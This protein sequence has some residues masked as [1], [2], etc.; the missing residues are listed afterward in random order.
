MDNQLE[1]NSLDQTIK[2]NQVTSGVINKDLPF[3]PVEEM[4]NTPEYD[5]YIDSADL[6][7]LQEMA[8]VEPL[9]NKYASGAYGN[10]AVDRPTLATDTYDPVVQ[11]NPLNKEDPDYFNRLMEIPASA[12]LGP[13]EPGKQIVSPKYAGI[14]QSNFQR[15]YNHP[16]FNKLGFTPYSDMETTYN[17][18]STVYDDYTRMWGQFTSLAGTGF[19]SG[20]RA[21]GDLFGGDYIGPDLESADEF[22]DAMAIGNSSRE[23]G[24]A[25]TNNML[26]NS[27]YTMGII[28][29]IALE[30][31]ALAAAAGLQGG[32]NPVSD[33]M[34]MSAT[35]R[36]IA[37]LKKIG[38]SVANSFSVTRYAN[39]TREVIKAFN[40]AEN[41]KDFW[42]M[43]KGITA[44]SGL[45]FFAPETVAAIRNLKTTANGTQ[46]M[47]NLAKQSTVFGGFY[48]DA[49][50]LNLAIAESKLEGGM[51]YNDMVR[52]GSNILSREN[53]GQPVTPEQMVNIEDKASRASFKTTLINAP[54][55]FA[56]NQLV[57]GNAFGGF[58]RSFGRLVND[59]VSDVGRRI[60][61]T[62]AVKSPFID[63]GESTLFNFGK[64]FRK[65][66]IN[67]GVKGNLIKSAGV[68]LRY[69]AANFG[70][71]IQEISQEAVSAGTKGYYTALLTDPLAGGIDLFKENINSAVSSQFTAQ[72]FD[73][74]MSG[75]LMGGVVSGPQKIFFQGIPAIYSRVSDPKAYAEHKENRKT[76]V[77]SIVKSYNEINDL[78]ADDVNSVFDPKKFEFLIQHQI[79]DAKTE[80]GFMASQFD[81]INESDYAKFQNIYN[82]M[83][84]GGAHYFEQ[85][86][87]DFMKLSDVEL[88]E[89]FPSS[90]KDV[91]S[92]KIRTRLQDMVNQIGKMEDNYTQLKDTF[93]NPFNESAFDISTQSTEREQELIRKLGWDHVRHLAMFTRDG[94]ERAVERSNSIFQTLSADPLF[95]NM[96]A[97][98]IT[99]LLDKDTIDQEINFLN[100]EIKN[101]K[102]DKSQA[103]AVKEKK[104]KVKKL[105][106]FKD[107]LNDLKNL[108]KDGSFDRRKKGKLKKAF[109]EYVR[110]L[111][112]ST[113]SFV[114]QD[115]MDEA[116]QQI[117]DYGALKGRA[118]V[119]DKTI[120]ALANPKKFNEVFERSEIA[121]KA[122][123]KNREEIFRKSVNKYLDT[124]EQNA[125]L[126]QINA[127]EGAFGTPIPEVQEVIQFGLTNNVETL[128]T[129]YNE[130]GLINTVNDPVAFNEINRL[131]NAYAKAAGPTQADVD[132][133]T[134]E[135]QTV[136]NREKIQEILKDIDVEVPV[137]ES[138]VLTS[139]L[140]KA[141][142]KYEGTQ[143]ALL[144]KSVKYKE[145]VNTQEGQTHREAFNAIKK[146][147][148]DNDKT[149]NDSTRQLT[150]EQ[151][152]NDVGLI[153]WLTSEE[154][155]NNDLV[156]QVLNKLKIPLTNI[157]GQDITLSGKGESFQGNDKLGIL[158]DARNANVAVLSKK[159]T[160]DQGNDSLVYQIIDSKTGELISGDMLKAAG[161]SSDINFFNKER[162]A[163]AAWKLV[164]L[165]IPNDGTFSFDGVE[166]L[167]FGAKV[168]SLSESDDKLNPIEYVIWSNP[169]KVIKKEVLT[170]IPASAVTLSAQEK[171]NNNVYINLRPGQFEN[172]YQ[173]EEKDFQL[174]PQNVS[175]INYAEPVTPYGG[176]NPEENDWSAAKQRYYS[177]LSV[178]SP[179]D[180]KTLE[181]VVTKDPEGGLT[182]SQYFIPGLEANPYILNKKAKYQIGVRTNSSDVQEK[183]DAFNFQNS[184]IRLDD[185]GID[186]NIFAYMPNDNFEFFGGVDPMS[187]T[188]QQLNQVIGNIE[189]LKGTLTKDQILDK[190][191]N[192]WAK[193]GLLISEVDRLMKDVPDGSF[194]TIAQSELP[195][196]LFFNA[197]LGNVVYDNS[198][199]RNLKELV[200]E[201]AADELG[202]YLIYQAE[203][204]KKG[205]R[206]V[207][208]SNL[209]EAEMQALEFR[210]KKS[211][212][213]EE[214]NKLLNG[215]D[216]YMAAVLLPDG[217][218]RLVPLKSEVLSS[219]SLNEIFVKLVERAQVTQKEN[220]DGKNP[221][222]NNNFNE[223]IREEL[224]IS[225]HQGLGIFLNVDIYGNIQL[226]AV[227]DE[228][229]TN[230]KL[231]KK[232]VNDKKL[233]V[234]KKLDDLIA[235]ANESDLFKNSV[236]GPQ[237]GSKKGLVL[238]SKN[239]RVSYGREVGI[240]ELIEKTETNA[241]P[242]VS[243]V[244]KIEIG[245]DSA[246]IQA[247]R[248]STEGISPA[249]S[250]TNTSTERLKTSEDFENSILILDEEEYNEYK[251]D[252]FENLPTEY[253]DDI[254]NKLLKEEELKEREKEVYD[255]RTKTIE[256][257]VF[258]KGGVTETETTIS[259]LEKLTQE[260][261]IL[262]DKLV[263]GKTGAAKLK[264][265]RSSDE[266]KALNKKIEDFG[267]IANKISP[268]LTSEDV[269]NIDVFM[270]WAKRNLPDYINIQDIVTLGNNMKAGGVR[271]GAFALNLN[272]LAGGLNISGTLYTGANS[273]F[274]YHEA[275][276]GVFRMLLTDTEISKYLSVARKEVRAKLRAEGK[277]F[278]QE[279]KMFRNS[280]DTYSN[281]SQSRLE[282]EYYE[283][284]LANEFE[285]FKT[286]PRS[287]NT[288]SSVKSLFTRMLEWI[289]SFFNSYNK[290]EL[291][292]L[293]EN[294]DAGKYK[295]SATVL[296]QF[297]NGLAAGVTLEANA[298]IP[299]QKVSDNDTEGYL[300][301]DSVVADSLVSSIA[302]MYLSRVSKITEP[303]TN[304]GEV[305]DKVLEDFYNLYDPESE[306]NVDKS[307]LQKETLNNIT[308][309]IEYYLDPLQ[310]QVYNILN[311]VDGQ[312]AEEE[313]NTEY[314]EDTIGV[315]AS[316]QWN[317]DAST[318]GGINSTPKQIR[319]Y[320]ATTT[321]SATDFFGNKELIKELKDDNGVVIRKAEPLIIPV[322]FTEI[323]NGMMKSAKNISDPKKML[324]TMYFF[325]QENAAT[326]AVVTRVLQD[327]GISEETLL[328]D[329]PLPNMKDPLL[330]QSIIK[331][332]ENF[333]VD[334]LFTQRDI[335]G[336]ILTY[337][338][339]Q[340]DDI[341]SQVDRWSQAWNDAYKKI[342]SNPTIAS[343]TEETLTSLIKL[344]NETKAKTS[345]KV[346][347]DARKYSQQLFDL[348]G[349][350]LSTQYLKYSILYNRVEAGNV[351]DIQQQA[352]VDLHKYEDMPLTSEVVR[353]MYSL[354]YDKDDI[355]SDGKDGMRSRIVK[356][357]KANAPFDETIGLSVFKNSE[358]NFV[359]SHQKPTFHLK[360]VEA[361]NNPS[362][363]EAKKEN[364]YLEDNYLL[365]SPAF[366]QMSNEKR[367][368][369]IRVAGT[370]V[371]KINST[372]EEINENISGV[373][374]KST[375][376][377]F[378]P[379][380]FALSL[381][382]SYTAL[383]NPQSGKVD[384]VEV[385]DPITNE[386]S[387][388]ALAPSLIRVL[389]SADTGDM[390]YMNVIKAVEFESGN[391]GAVKI[392]DKVIDV[393]VNSINTE[394]KRIQRESNQ[395][396][397]TKEE[398]VGYNI[399][400]VDDKGDPL[401]MR[402]Y[403]LHNSARLLTSQVKNQLEQIAKRSDKTTLEQA[404]LEQ[405][406]TMDDLRS[407]VRDKLDLQFE[408][409]KVELDSLDI[410]N[411]ISLNIKEGLIRAGV[412]STP[413]LEESNYLLNLN[414]DLNHNLK[415]IFLND[416][417]NTQAINE[418]FL[419][420]QA[421]TLKNGVDAIKRAK[422]QNAAY[423]SA[424]SAISAP[425][426][427]VNHSVD[428]ISLVAIEEPREAS[429]LTGNNIDRADAQMWMTTKA[430]RY[431]TFAF[432]QLTPLIANLYDKIEQGEDITSWQIFGENV[433]VV[434]HKEES[435]IV[436]DLKIFDRNNIEVFKTNSDDRR[437][438]F[439][440][441]KKGETVKL[442][443]YV[444]QDNAMLISKK[445]VYFDGTTFIKMSAFVLTP[446]LTSD[447]VV[448]EDGSIS[449]VA[450]PN[451]VELHNLRMKLE[452]IESLPG[453]NT[454]GIA[455]PLTALKMLK[456]RVQTLDRLNEDAP[457]KEG[458]YTTLSAMDMGLQSVNP[459]NKL[460]SVDPTQ[461]K[462]IVTSEQIDSTPI[463][464]MG[465][466]EKD[467]VMTVGDVRRL[468]NKAISSR[469][470][471]NFKNKRNLIFTFDG[472]M[473]ELAISKT[474]GKLTPNLMAFLKYATEGLKAS[475]SSSQLLEFFSTENGEQKYNLNSQIT[476]NRFEQLF[477][478]YLSKG[479]FAEKQPA[480][481]LTLVSD[482]GLPVYR[483][484]FSV[485]A[486]GI[487]ERS[488]VIREKVWEKMKNKP[489]IVEFDTL[490]RS[491][492][493][494]EG[495]VVLDRLRSNVREYDSKGEFT[496][497]RYTEMLMPAH[498]QSVMDLVENG[499]M[500]M[501][502]AI[503]KMFAIRIPSQDN[504]ST[505]NVK[506]VDFLPAF[507]GSSAAFA[508]E[509]IEI[510]G[511]DFDIDKVYAQIK[512]F[513]VRDGEFVEYGKAEDSQDKYDEY[514]QYVQEKVE[515]KG[516]AYNEALS[517]YKNDNQSVRED[518][519]AALAFADS[520]TDQE[521]KKW[522][523]TIIALD[524]LG[525]PIS[526]EQ[527]LKYLKDH[528]EPYQAP[529]NNEV[530]DY[531]YALMGNT[532]VTENV[533]YEDELPISY[534]PANLDILKAE[535][536]RLINLS[537][538][539]PNIFAIR[540]EEDSV[541]INNIL[542]KIKAFKNNKGAAIG[543]I[544]SPNVNLSLLTEYGILIEDKSKVITINGVSFDNFAVL[545]EQTADETTGVRKQ[546]IISSLI[547]MATDDAKERLVAKLGLNRS[548]LGL[549]GNLT[550]LGM[551][552]HTSLLLIN[553]P[554]IQNIYNKALNK[555][556]KTDPGVKTL[557]ESELESF[558]VR[559]LEKVDV[560]DKLLYEA[561]ARPADLSASEN[562][563]ILEE[564][565]KGVQIQEFTAKMTSISNLTTGL[566]K[567]IAAVNKK[568]DDINSLL[569]PDAMMDLSKIYKGKTWQS[570]YVEIFN[571]VVDQI[572]PVTF[573]SA[574]VSFQTILNKTLENVNQKNIE[575]N[576]DAL[577]AVSR[578][579]L[580]Y[581]T[582]KAY[583]HN[584]LKSENNSQV[585]AN[586]NNNFI[587]PVSENEANNS[588]VK[589]IDK[590]RA[591][592]DMQENFFLK[593]FVQLSTANDQSNQTGMN[594][595][596]ANT[597]LSMN[598][599]QKVDLQTSFAQIYGTAETKNDALSII[600]YM[601]VK[602]GLQLKYG[603]LL[604]A[605]SPFIMNGF[606]SQIDTAN[607]GLRNASDEK[608]KSTFGLTFDEFQ[609][610][611]VD[612]YMQSNVNNALLNTYTVL[613]QISSVSDVSK[614]LLT[615]RENKSAILQKG[616]GKGF[617]YLRVKY[618]DSFSNPIYITYV[619]TDSN[620]GE[621]KDSKKIISDNYI[622]VPTY[623]SN[624]QSGIG[625]M[626]GP[627]PTYTENRAYV[628][629]K[630]L[631]SNEADKTVTLAESP[632]SEKQEAAESALQN[633]NA[634]IEATDGLVKVD[635]KNIAD[636]TDNSASAEGLMG[637]LVVQS[638][639]QTSEFDIN[640]L[641]YAESQEESDS[642][643]AKG[644]AYAGKNDDG[645]PAYYKPTQPTSEVESKRQFQ[646][647]VYVKAYDN[648]RNK[649][650]SEL[651]SIVEAGKK[652]AR[653]GGQSSPISVAKSFIARKILDGKTKELD[654]QFAKPT[655]IGEVKVLSRN[656]SIAQVAA[657]NKSGGNINNL[658]M[659][660]KDLNDLNDN[661]V[662]RLMDYGFGKDNVLVEIPTS[663]VK[664]STDVVLG[665]E[666]DYLVEVFEKEGQ[667]NPIILDKNFNIIEGRH[668]LFAAKKLGL[669]IKAYMPAQ[670][671][672]EE[673][674]NREEFEKLSRSELSEAEESVTPLDAQLKLDLFNA[675]ANDYSALTN[676]WTKEIQGNA[677]FKAKLREQKIL[678]LEDFIAL[679]K[680]GIYK[681]DEDFLESLGCL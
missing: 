648:L 374:Y 139:I 100:V 154:G 278:E 134:E 394:Y 644:Y 175:R 228:V 95:E 235:R 106:A 391:S 478:S 598:P 641:E 192:N 72:G 323:Y 306:H 173:L 319:A 50:S 128:R 511:A 341:N 23:G 314:F 279:L 659:A 87:R 384:Y 625:F 425:E 654:V 459:S 35:A 634:N 302:A 411:S 633:Q 348:T 237:T 435:Y 666:E 5:A 362:V 3:I 541:D 82:V 525:L 568:K 380:E 201:G 318:I 119:Y 196:G 660:N 113:G 450:K 680:E 533:A 621:G 383:A 517:L 412:K 67:A 240:E 636:I 622:E 561:I 328:N 487:P 461:I 551:P 232:D 419:G 243:G 537:D 464:G 112:K 209:E 28:S 257:I 140:E 94:F 579:L 191:R 681:S 121:I 200:N 657:G 664:G 495:L 166:D 576:E 286:N 332:F 623:G 258:S 460:E 15:Y 404:M 255:A 296:N 378:T 198:S 207:P 543:A 210:V 570:K 476:V 284:Y 616:I 56:T 269:E 299:Y 483:R 584:Q 463:P 92:G 287:T 638:T 65:S 678:S 632:E 107:I 524:M 437:A 559:S 387:K 375:Y 345:A 310:K 365:N 629:S 612:G 590:L 639:Q 48:R 179:E 346:T 676:Y 304:R 149:V 368:R 651:K 27:G 582:I 165:N 8:N 29:S 194:L 531:K 260:R 432:G 427:G 208:I 75:F 236:S 109:Q 254:A 540:N 474:K 618:D 47:V 233:T 599:L 334:Y 455:A 197:I 661:L 424:Y 262:R 317:T 499:T 229:W 117:V 356:M 226:S 491:E 668:R 33:A 89:A 431:M 251:A 143:L 521:Y 223:E 510:S 227:K 421:V 473:D 395:D 371:G 54:L 31:V 382:N 624:Q 390:M 110:F 442:D 536:K 578:D 468:Y 389:E 529:L 158:P 649:P 496:G 672:S 479:T 312:I 174:L 607:E 507:Y 514:L 81:F 281:M 645:L 600:N 643:I 566:G 594:L 169:D 222:F 142:R 677:E 238:S 492:I 593:S 289:K 99:V 497:L 178:L 647:K 266:L 161:V 45:A 494:K 105:S 617:D 626:F 456:Q 19:M 265:L 241:R 528:G 466:N 108:T 22:A 125:L 360:Q 500:P 591:R 597:F 7:V 410:S 321:M 162:E 406:M 55:I 665:K 401:V 343:K 68:G 123:Y 246:S 573:L 585:V 315:R 501:P 602:D 130:K 118:K 313:Y 122:I 637:L 396:A 445:L 21:I 73:T 554:I 358:G 147:W 583:Q 628:R 57:L 301:L 78:N 83:S 153:N 293:F 441:A 433:K 674:L 675:L 488:E 508:Q 52:E 354:I 619:R 327:I 245:A 538:D 295:T 611:F 553:N 103:D 141:Y 224:F 43:Q 221:A 88:A 259:P 372:E 526:K 350:R 506:H 273:P 252:N 256:I 152:K 249:K 282:Q 46:N 135:V 199:T 205:R 270:D 335:N 673:T 303:N 646:N 129:F 393:F 242:E 652:S 595:A 512:D 190:I 423:I 215:S 188:R 76:F 264:A 565:L 564:F 656:V 430:S 220:T 469:I 58:N 326:G 658:T 132:T 213:I 480:V 457:F 66:V 399:E 182:T 271:V 234:N 4:F 373:S 219:E 77:D 16:E 214:L 535:L 74:F 376:G 97:S 63:A 422:A 115:A 294:I 548:A 555:K 187:L 420:D 614:K 418:I 414:S 667:V 60:L 40:T 91:K 601:M 344:L 13:A 17:A 447:K 386:K 41:A 36:N 290:N 516:S 615:N 475:Q 484:V 443:G 320:F 176:K 148:I 267:N 397:A 195:N 635:G 587:Y 9:I 114:N 102:D 10:M 655:Q 120:E 407:E 361:L 24:M 26:L 400:G 481:T 167:S 127:I 330:F 244:S 291:L 588:I 470:E 38:S 596:E 347:E 353:E 515:K 204:G 137:G 589:L 377:N 93:P 426:H 342:K 126:N 580:S 562:A 322:P 653:S 388:V 181:F 671:T 138:Q 274:R 300:F 367:Q 20:Y 502:E 453:K 560:T 39:K 482:F 339:A 247:K 405:N 504:H 51:V 351:K 18:N 71:G 539:G 160:D 159:A 98:D 14:R 477:L 452:G 527:Y 250:T 513:Y 96:A 544:V 485:N 569:D 574:S 261:D 70:E 146:I 32:L 520:M 186:T 90:K 150:Q 11:Q 493:P 448:A 471:I 557:T 603:S 558:P 111:A 490:L 439:E 34:L 509:L 101:L 53:Y 189:G 231:D 168:Y 59:Q 64:G 6:S 283:E 157:S 185:N 324:Q 650:E 1:N 316:S 203:A 364:L 505:I 177:I 2:D 268:V 276:H 545:R 37:R 472:A 446:Q 534:Q 415:Q 363:L 136:E 440:L 333:R 549:V 212:G 413:A 518:N 385:T 532:G 434:E 366:M 116:L 248:N 307:E 253:F 392:T 340:R 489:D 572:L 408:E 336:N 349:I 30:E 69:F 577:A 163:K 145:W 522:A 604:D 217:T 416:W 486:N 131:K 669:P 144:Q 280:A 156:G 164:S 458:D 79:A 451:R 523:N 170:L 211:I 608:M 403:S 85:Q 184:F 552:I 370:K 438:I 239:F 642:L 467:E 357:S 620:F 465:L 409:F 609:K 309:A 25:W 663:M 218:Y 193:Q 462:A 402:A 381:I 631:A 519:P 308:K 581:V 202:N 225:G 355:F 337:S 183:I 49:R 155:R 546:D 352:L 640:M 311:V 556:E 80:A 216:A 275:F 575:F 292:T 84:T 172:E 104:E 563:A 662:E 592:E 379:Q 586:L 151:I 206:K 133:A 331:A 44:G 42:S 359:N 180:I 454:L 62:K 530:L 285:K 613:T 429:A 277:N 86:M 571:Q 61:K 417:I 230:F 298:L 679:R 329:S 567:D 272:H 288:D 398:I 124:E 503:S 606:L 627:R 436:K 325:G 428:D 605:I 498:F 542:G 305:F 369:V 670:Q 263:A 12:T 171:V 449:W 338:A 297:T 547:T 610:E 630:N 444:N 550:A